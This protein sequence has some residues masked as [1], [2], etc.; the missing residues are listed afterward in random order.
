MHNNIYFLKTA[1]SI[2]FFVVGLSLLAINSYGI[3]QDTRTK[4]LEHTKTEQLRFKNKNY[5]SY[6]ETIEQLNGLQTL[7]EYEYSIKANKLV[8][9][10]LTHVKWNQVDPIEFRQ[11]VPIWENYFLYFIGVFSNQPQLERYHFVDYRR[12]LR[13]GIGICGD[14]SLVLSQILDIKKISNKIISFDGHVI[15]E[16]T[17]KNKKKSLFD[18]DFGVFINLS[19]EE[20]ISN[21]YSAI[22]SY[23]DAGYSQLETEA[24]LRI[25]YSNHHYFNNVKEF[26]T[27][28]YY[29]EY[30]SYI[31]KW[32]LPILLLFFAVLILKNR[33]NN[34]HIM[35]RI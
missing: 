20:L 5:L 30:I 28:R 15:N 18:P 23:R 32:L 7:P 21:P 34:L 12:S 16:V 33:K 8:N 19:L 14:A 29:F 1:L 22:Q 27:K 26:M 4:G 9:D 6:Q 31:L 3:F 24:L 13:R 25:Y 17:F 2:L 10:G 11:L 35:D